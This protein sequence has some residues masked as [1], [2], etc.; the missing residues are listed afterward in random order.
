MTIYSQ[1]YVGLEKFNLDKRF[2]KSLIR[3]T[4]KERVW[5]SEEPDSSESREGI[6][7]SIKTDRKK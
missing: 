1:S 7:V 4:E 3:L 5:L 6:E 2:K